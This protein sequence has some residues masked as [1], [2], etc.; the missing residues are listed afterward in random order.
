MKS[1]VE[2]CS[3]MESIIKR[4]HNEIDIL[5]DEL[6]IRGMEMNKKNVEIERL[7]RVCCETKDE[8]N[9]KVMILR[10]KICVLEEKLEDTKC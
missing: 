6:K 5:R 2:Y 9:V 4:Q 7:K 3:D 1:A 8:L 10:R